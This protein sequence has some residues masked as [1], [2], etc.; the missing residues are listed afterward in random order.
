[1]SLR[2][3]TP[4]IRRPG[5]GPG[6]VSPIVARRP[7]LEREAL[8]DVGSACRVGPPMQARRSTGAGEP[9]VNAATSPRSAASWSEAHVRMGAEL[10]KAAWE[11]CINLCHLRQRSAPVD[12]QLVQ[13]EHQ[14]ASEGCVKV[15]HSSFR[16]CSVA[17]IADTDELPGELQGLAPMPK[18]PRYSDAGRTPVSSRCSRARVQAT[19]R[20][21]RSVS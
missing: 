11:L 19:Y 21:R 13:V 6:A 4:P 5:F 15:E 7:P 10:P 14:R 3:T 20:S 17:C 8:D 18:S 12:R 16:S 1:M 2:K 9:R